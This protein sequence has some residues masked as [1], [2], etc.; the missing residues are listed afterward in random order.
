MANEIDD[1]LALNNVGTGETAST[2][3]ESKMVGAT[4]HLKVQ[5]I[6]FKWKSFSAVG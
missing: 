6:V 1:K 4:D 3:L 5:L 2:A